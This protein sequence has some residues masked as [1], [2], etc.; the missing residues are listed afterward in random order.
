[1]P[2]PIMPNHMPMHDTSR[3]PAGFEAPTYPQIDVGML[4]NLLP[5]P[6]KDNRKVSSN[7]ASLLFRFWKN[8]DEGNNDSYTVPQ[9]FS[10][11]DVLRLKSLGFLSGDTDVVKLTARGKE[12]IK[13][14]VLNEENTYESTRVHKPYT[15]ILAEMDRAKKA[16]IRTALGR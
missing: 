12:V 1:M 9:C 3:G 16:G 11:N 14:I 5:K 10:N 15:E 8:A 13:N 4:N 6:A 7:D 2:V